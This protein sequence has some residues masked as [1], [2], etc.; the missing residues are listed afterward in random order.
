LISNAIL[1]G[2]LEDL[3]DVISLP[4]WYIMNESVKSGVVPEEWKIANVAPRYKLAA[5]LIVITQ[6]AWQVKIR[7][8]QL[9][10]MKDAIREHSRNG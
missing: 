2:F 3:K 1:A 8:L 7:K 10:I 9:S 4:A 6:Y 5:T